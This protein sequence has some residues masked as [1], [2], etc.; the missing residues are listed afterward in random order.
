[1]TDIGQIRLDTDTTVPEIGLAE[2]DRDVAMRD[3]YLV[4]FGPS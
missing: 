3:V 2:V 1:M 4:R